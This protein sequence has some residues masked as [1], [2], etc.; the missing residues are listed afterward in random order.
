MQRL[1][2]TYKGM[3]TG[4]AMVLI[5][6]LFCFI[7]KLDSPW[8]YATYFIYT[9]GIMWTLMSFSFTE[10]ND[11]KFKSFF[12]EGFKCFIMVTLLMVIF[13]WIYYKLNP[14]VIEQMIEAGSKQMQLE[15]NYTPAEITAK[16]TDVRKEALT[17]LTFAAVV[18]YLILGVLI[19]CFSSYLILQSKKK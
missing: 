6:L 17:M 5:T 1:N 14:Q 7:N 11:R 16:A 12:S 15:H 4:I 19:T 2:A 3:V 10:L 18:K 8:M 9:A 13:W